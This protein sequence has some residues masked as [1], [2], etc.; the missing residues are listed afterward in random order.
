MKKSVLNFFEENPLLRQMSSEDRQALVH[1]IEQECVIDTISGIIRDVEEIME[2]DP[3]LEEKRVLQIAAEKIVKNL[4][5]E[6]ASIRLFDPK[7]LRMTRFGAY[8]ISEAER[9]IDVPLEDSISGRVVR[10]KRSIPISSLLEEPYFKD[11]IEKKGFHSL[12]AVPLR[13]PS[14]QGSEADILGS[15]QIYYKEDNRLFNP[16][17]I[18]RAELLARRTTYVLA[19]RKILALQKLNIHKERIVDKIF[20]R[21]SK[22]EGIKLKDLFMALIPDLDAYLQVKSCSLFSVSKDLRFMRL[23]AAYPLDK[24]YHR[25]GHTFTVSHHPYFQTVIYGASDYGDHPFERID[26][27]YLLIK[28]PENSSLVSPGM[29]EFVKKN[30]IHSILIVSLKAN[31]I[32]RYLMSFFAT[33]QKSSFTNEEIDLLTFFG[34]EIMKALRLEILDDILHDFKNPAIAITGFANRAKKLLESED[35]EK[36]REKLTTYVDIIVKETVRLQDLAM[37]M[38]MEGREEVLDLSLIAKDRFS[39]NKEA[40]RESLRKNIQ[41]KPLEIEENLLVYCS[42]F[43]LERVFD[44]LLSNAVKAIPK[45]GGILAM[46]CFEEENTACLEIRNTGEIP[47]ERIDQVKRGEVTG[48][49]LNIIHRF[50]QANHGEIYVRTEAGQTIFTI[51]LPLHCPESQP[52]VPDI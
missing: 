37:A 3:S 35:F 14:F 41:A 42:R 21:L 18:I 4:R 33:E 13:I 30:Q 29:R 8:Q 5:A 20:V 17:E 27:A 36:I 12:L 11:I 9:K 31:E 32:V 49:G 39:L 23:E 25:L 47:S 7:S 2:I 48:R 22:R 52:V 51:K 50:V 16:M 46:R 24:T 40:I 43:G 34:K 44:N 38:S 10:E 15:L 28:D 1:S 19:K 45:H 6:A 26:P